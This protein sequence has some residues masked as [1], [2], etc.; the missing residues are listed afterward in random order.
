MHDF[1][2]AAMR[3]AEIEGLRIERDT[4]LSR[5]TRFGL[6]GSASILVDASAERALICAI[7]RLESD[8]LPY[9]VIG[10]GSNLVVADAGYSGV[11][12]RYTANAIS[13]K[14]TLVQADA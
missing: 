4:P 8:G 12:L 10:G 3:L 13:V 9:V 11:V 2:A 7:A 1:S 6:G 14:G 5:Y